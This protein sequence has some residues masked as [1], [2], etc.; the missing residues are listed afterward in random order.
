MVCAGAL[1]FFFF[2][3]FGFGWAGA[4]FGSATAAA[5]AGCAGCSGG[6]GGGC[7]WLPVI[8]PSA[9][10]C[11]SSR[12]SLVTYTTAPFGFVT[13]MTSVR[14]LAGRPPGETATVTRIATAAA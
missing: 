1:A 2:A 5:G 7:T 13:L 4:G 9:G 14:A 10:S 8:T 11:A 3:G 12:P 6:G